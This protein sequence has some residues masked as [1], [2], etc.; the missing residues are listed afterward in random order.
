MQRK[1]IFLVV[2]AV[3]IMFAHVINAADIEDI[4]QSVQSEISGN[5]ARDYTM[6]LWRHDKWSTLPEWKKA[7]Q[8][9]KI[10]MEERNYDEAVVYEVPA[11]GRTMSGAWTNP[12]GWDVAQATL[13]VIEPSGMPDLFRYLANYRDNP[14]SLNAW[15]AP[16][17]PEGIETELVL[18]ESNDPEELSRLDARG[19]IVLTGMYTRGIK[20]Y[21]DEY[22]ILGYVSDNIESPNV[23][24]VTANQWL[25]GWSDIPGGW[26]MTDYDSKNDFCFSVSKKKA[27]YLRGLLRQGIKVKVRA[28]IDSRYYSDDTLPYVVGLVEGAG[29]ENEE[30]LIT[31]HMNEWGANDNS[32]GSSAILEAVGTLNHLIRSGKLPRP[33][34]SIRVLL[35]AEMYGSLP[36]VQKFLE[37][38][39]TKTIAAVCCDTGAEDYDL[40]STTV[41]I[42]NNPNVCPTYTD[43]VFPEIA[44]M[45]YSQYAPHRN[46]KTA[47]FSMGTDTYFCEPMIGVPT[48]LIYMN[49]GGHLHHNSMDTIEKVDPRSLRELSFLNAS[50]LYYIAD[51]GYEEVPFVAN[52]TFNRGIKVIIGIAASANENL[53]SAENGTALG[54]ALS[55]G[56][57]RIK[58][59]T[60]L[61]KKALESI[62]S[63]VPPGK[64]DEVRKLILPYKRTFDDFEKSLSLQLV[65]GAKARADEASVK[66]MIP[67]KTESAWEKQAALIIPKRNYFATL[68]LAEVPVEEWR[69]VKSTPRW[70]SS[71]NWA[72]ASYWWCDGKRNLNEIKRLCELEAG[73]PVA[74]FDLINYY[75]FLNKYGYVDFVNSTK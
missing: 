18:M 15:S 45:Y 7:I 3:F 72:S 65:D 27:D 43:A 17:P 70:W 63:L 29:T 23:D 11:D 46:W 41:S 48:N 49:A 75:N 69:E 34:R 73:R 66:I 71:T 6:R 8:E 14:T 67:D 31:G 12:L 38:L 22:G 4:F 68:F 21:L 25:N 59:Y 20:R 47:P 58:Y 9:A 62:L 51:A 30:I 50:Y 54:I 24:F 61:Q 33:K 40:H 5:R 60:D 53:F 37:R 32:T 44:R 2:M 19:K 55:G 13:E 36:Y 39:Q 57:E 28:K 1:R 56:L 52:L 64:K 42:H 26:W 10:I 35:G 74:G 16:T